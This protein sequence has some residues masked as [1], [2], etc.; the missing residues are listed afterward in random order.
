[1]L[2]LNGEWVNDSKYGKQFKLTSYQTK[3]PETRKGIERFLASGFIPGIGAELAKRL[4]AR[5]GLDT[6]E[7]MGRHPEK[8]QQV[9]G[10]GP[11]R[12]R[13]IA[14]A[15]VEQKELQDVMVFLRGHD[16]PA[17]FAVRIYQRYGAEAIG[18][19]R[20]NPY[21]LA[22]DIWG[23]GFKTADRI[24]QSLGIARTAPERLEAG[25]VHVL[26]ELTENG[27]V[28]VPQQE[29][30]EQAAELLGVDLDLLEEPLRR[31]VIGELVV[32][33]TLGDRGQCVSL[34]AMWE[35]E[36]E[37]AS[38]LAALVKTPMKPLDI[39]LGKALTWF[40]SQADLTLADQQRGAIEAAARDKCVVITGGPGVGKTT[41]VR[42]VVRIFDEAKKR[43]ALA[44][45]TGRAA[46]RLSE[47]TKTG[48]VTLHRLLEYQPQSGGFGRNQELPLDAD[49]VIVD[50]A[51][52]IDIVLFNALVMALRPRAQLIL[53]GDID[54]LPSVGPGSVLDDIIASGA[55]AVVRLTEIFRQAASS[56]IIVNAHRINS[57]ESP[58]LET[59]KSGVDSDFYFI[60]RDDPIAARDTLLELV[61]TRI[62]RKFGFDPV[63]E[64]QVLTPMHRGDLG[65]VAL[66][67]ALQQELNPKRDG[68][69][70]MRRGD[71]AFRVGDKVMQIKNDYDKDVFNGDIGVVTGVRTPG[72]GAD[73]ADLL[74]VKLLDGREITYEKNELDRLIHAYAVSVHKSQGSEYPCIV[75]TLVSQHYMMLQRNLL[76]T[77]L[78]RGKQLV[79]LLGS[80]RAVN[81]AVRNNSN[82]G[83]Y[84][85]LAERIREHSEI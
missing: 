75:L 46:K 61:A 57:G 69:R 3:S 51:S 11:S 37:A 68:M 62:P 35:A 42:G 54:Q 7:V 83:R 45:P 6:L 73:S 59:N 17:A 79:I 15:W 32:R 70:E 10:I 14:A 55:G 58:D 49:V 16:V 8:L 47:S 71:R 28:H 2:R 13:S 41:I 81:A 76:Y 1:M 66:N 56:A 77:A 82:R 31:L 52:M 80:K 53:V 36:S 30:L 72:I 29:L 48:A 4:V 23:I 39:D 5:F 24:A 63:T 60:N 50:E 12:A 27:H 26:G 21:R 40:E 19:V 74:H 20:Q 33:E 38:A 84:T 34:T 22:L 64:V 43:V 44:A 85:W 78:T 67:K 65:T 18:I 25:L 9:D